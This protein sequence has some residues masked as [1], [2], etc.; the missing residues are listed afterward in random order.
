MHAQAVDTRPTFLSEV[1]PGS[2]AIAP[3]VLFMFDNVFCAYIARQSRGEEP[4]T[5]AGD[6]EG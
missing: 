5:D 6:G 3:A 2:K 1:R 4:G